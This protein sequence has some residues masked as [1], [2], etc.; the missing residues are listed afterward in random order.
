MSE[1]PYAEA[2]GRIIDQVAKPST[3]HTLARAEDNVRK[4]GYP[5]TISHEMA[6]ELGLVEPTPEEAEHRAR[7]AAE[8]AERRK[9]GVAETGA[10]IA[11]LKAITD[12][13]SRKVLDLH[14]RIHVD[15]CAGCEFAGYEAE[16]PMWPCATVDL[17]AEHHSI[18][19]PSLIA[20][21]ETR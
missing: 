6:L 14:H 19:A 17:I 21:E 12:P 20:F 15:Q 7:Q 4:V 18:A 13:V 1:N 8:W 16:P 9:V 11:A 5:T 10:Y 3:L 2:I